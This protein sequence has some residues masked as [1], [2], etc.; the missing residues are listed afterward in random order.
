MWFVLIGVLLI[1]L[2]LLEVGPVDAWSWWSVLSPFPLAA[3]WWWW[4]DASGYT[5][6]KEMDKMDER[7]VARRRKSLEALGLDHR[8]F[9]KQQKKAN[10]F[11]SSRQRVIDRVEGKRDEHRKKLRDSILQSRFQS[12]QMS[13]QDPDTTPSA[14]AKQ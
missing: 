12:S 2:K 14:K 9:D 5:R 10:A 3:V 1:A 11:K 13:E 6:R 4:A 8:A 7:K